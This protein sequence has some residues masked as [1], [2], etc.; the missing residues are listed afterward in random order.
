MEKFTRLEGVAAPLQIPNVDT[1]MMISK[2][3]LKTIKRAGLGKGLFS[4]RRYKENA[5]KSR[6]SC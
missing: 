2:Q 3:Y 6:I 4:E 5:A 1:D